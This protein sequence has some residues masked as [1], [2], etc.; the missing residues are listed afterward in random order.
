ARAGV[1]D[2]LPAATR[3][4]LVAG[5]G[6]RGDSGSRGA[7]AAASE[8]TPARPASP[9]D[10]TFPHCGQNRAPARTAAPHETHL[11]EISG[12]IEKE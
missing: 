2:S 8:D 1:G 12:S 3:T 11:R 6:G 4:S 10:M 5:A 9:S 7:A